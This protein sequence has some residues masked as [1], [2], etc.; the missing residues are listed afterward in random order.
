VQWRPVIA[1]RSLGGGTVAPA[2]PPRHRAALG[3]A[4]GR[5]RPMATTIRGQRYDW[6]RC[7]RWPPR[8][9]GLMARPLR[10]LAIGFGQYGIAT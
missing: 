10:S 2:S 1:A 3:G 7:V 8:T 6:D 9:D 5:V 4:S